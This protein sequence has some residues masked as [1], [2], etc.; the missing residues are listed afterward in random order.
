MFPIMI[1]VCWQAFAAAAS[2][3]PLIGSLLLSNVVAVAINVAAAH[4]TV[5]AM[6][7]EVYH[8]PSFIRKMWSQWTPGLKRKLADAVLEPAAR[9]RA[10]HLCALSGI[11]CNRRDLGSSLAPPPVPSAAKERKIKLD[12]VSP[13][14][15]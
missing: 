10:A 13:A 2:P 11:P 6:P 8:W 14:W 7:L 3:Y 1:L 5:D 15:A 9:K 4:F 12:A